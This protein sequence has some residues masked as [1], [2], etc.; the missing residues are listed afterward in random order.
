LAQAAAAEQQ[1]KILVLMV[2][3]QY[4][5][6]IQPLVVVMEQARLQVATVALVAQVAITVF[7]AELEH[8][9]RVMQVG[10]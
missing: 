10:R 9:L 3:I 7:Q 8:L 6:P 5:I 1:D 2:V 4:S